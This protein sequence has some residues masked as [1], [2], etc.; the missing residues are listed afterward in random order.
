MTQDK[1]IH[2][3]P[4]EEHVACNLR[5]AFDRIE[6]YLTDPYWTARDAYYRNT[7]DSCIEDGYT[8]DEAFEAGNLF[9][10]E[11]DKKVGR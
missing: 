8:P 6:D 10:S 11:Y 3:Y 5:V 9:L 7:I 4:I 1:K 2:Y